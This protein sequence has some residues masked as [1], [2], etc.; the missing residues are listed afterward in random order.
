MRDRSALVQTTLLVGSPRKGSRTGGIAVRLVEELSLALAAEGVELAR[1]EIVDLAD[2]GAALPLRASRSVPLGPEIERCLGLVRRAGL[3]MVV[4]PTFK[5][6]YTGLLKLFLDMLPMD[7]LA[8][9]V[10]VGAMTAGWAKHRGAG[11][12]YLRPLL[13]ELGATAPVPCLSILE[14][15]FEDVPGV[16]AGWSRRWA[17]ALGAVVRHQRQSAPPLVSHPLTGARAS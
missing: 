9:C 10:A 6:T 14:E 7:G 16:V 12:Q 3:L 11:D 17:P 2:V 5:G 15:E 13:T 4:S 1:P 8:D